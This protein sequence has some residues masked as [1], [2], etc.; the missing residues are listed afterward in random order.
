MT[1]EK[2]RKK[3]IIYLISW[4]Q[5]KDQHHK[6]W[7]KNTRAALEFVSFDSELKI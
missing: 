3:H 7:V 6:C 4:D 1:A 2:L 5:T